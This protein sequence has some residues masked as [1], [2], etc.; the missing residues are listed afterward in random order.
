[1]ISYVCFHSFG[2]IYRALAMCWALN[3]GDIAENK[4]QM[5]LTFQ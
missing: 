5:G 3:P 2:G 1:M 4:P